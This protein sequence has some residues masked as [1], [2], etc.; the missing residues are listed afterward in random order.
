[1]K[2]VPMWAAHLVCAVALLPLTAGAADDA[3]LRE[4]R[5]EGERLAAAFA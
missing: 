4:L 1:M 2:K 3:A 5:A